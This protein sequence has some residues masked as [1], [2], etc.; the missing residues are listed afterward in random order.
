MK[1]FIAVLAVILLASFSDRNY[2]TVENILDSSFKVYQISGYQGPRID[3][4]KDSLAQFL[5]ALHYNI[6]L[7]DIENELKGEIES[8]E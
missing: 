7:S 3:I 1:T 2:R 5:T 6:P 8:K 4:K